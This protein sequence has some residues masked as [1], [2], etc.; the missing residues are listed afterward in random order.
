[1]VNF[2][3][4]SLLSGQESAPRIQCSCIDN[5]QDRKYDII[6]ATEEGHVECVQ[7][8]IAQGCDLEV[9]DPV[10]GSGVL[11][12]AVNR[13]HIVKLLL[14]AG[15]NV[16]GVIT[17]DGIRSSPLVA[18]CLNM[19]METIKLLVEEGADP[20]PVPNA[21]YNEPPLDLVAGY[22]L[23]DAVKLLVI[24]G[25]SVNLSFQGSN[26]G[27]GT[28]LCKAACA[29][30]SR[31]VDY[32]VKAGTDLSIRAVSGKTPLM[33]ASICYRNLY[34]KTKCVQILIK[35]GSE[36]NAKSTHGMSALE[37]AARGNNR[38]MMEM[39]LV[40]N[41][42]INDPDTRTYTDLAT[43]AKCEDCQDDF[44]ECHDIH[45]PIM[46]RFI[47]NFDISCI[48]MVCAAGAKCTKAEVEELRRR[49]DVVR[50]YHGMNET[51]ID[52]II[53]RDQGLSLTDICRNNLR[54]H[55]IDVCQTSAHYKNLFIAVPRLP[56]PQ[57]LKDFL[58]YDIKPQSPWEP[59]PDMIY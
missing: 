53:L 27:G 48:N 21:Q 22:G 44:E 17:S 31:V 13:R 18:A 5:T 39:L 41:A 43:R 1:M 37:Y 57:K 8:L 19:D 35:A 59:L 49:R 46:S 28:A 33:E 47:Q 23:L 26:D 2:V 14:A 32:L 4:F 12:R 20:N 11:R 38:L 51:M 30:H 29:G 24:A 6:S 45:L 40:A 58:L 7:K 56:L 54:Q 52:V 3:L 34:E 9:K 25:A 42:Q 15:I 36:I 55:L 50:H 10:W 16:D